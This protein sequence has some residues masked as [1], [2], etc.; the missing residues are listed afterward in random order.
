MPTRRTRSS[1]EAS[2]ASRHVLTSYAAAVGGDR[3]LLWRCVIAYPAL[4]AAFAVALQTDVA[5]TSFLDP[6]NAMTAYIGASMIE[7]FGGEVAVHGD[8]LSYRGQTARVGTGCSGAELMMVLVPAI[9]VFP[10]SLRA[11]LI[12]VLAAIAFV[13]PL[14]AVRVS[15]LT[16]LLATDMQLFELAHLYF[17]Q[18]LLIACLVGFFLAWL[19]VTRRYSTFARPE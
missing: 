7:L 5:E 16:V 11:R 14:N 6:S 13:F 10:A 19:E 17:W 12:G 3:S 2:P 9:L 4:V 1:R 8:L 18:A 15:T